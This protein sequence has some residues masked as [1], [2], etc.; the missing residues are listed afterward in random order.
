MF[1]PWIRSRTDLGDYAMSKLKEAL[2]LSGIVVA[3]LTFVGIFLTAIIS[4]AY[5]LSLLVKILEKAAA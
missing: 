3:V 1:L 4:V 5:V 2:K